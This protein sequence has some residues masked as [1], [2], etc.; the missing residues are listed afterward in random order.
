MR[1]ELHPEA[2]GELRSAALWYDERGTGLGDEFIVEVRLPSI[3]LATLQNP[4]RRGRARG[5]QA[6]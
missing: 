5:L 2:R 6:R 4:T 3:E 1:L